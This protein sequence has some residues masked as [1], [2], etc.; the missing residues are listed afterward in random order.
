MPYATI[1]VMCIKCGLEL[2]PDTNGVV[3]LELYQR[4]TQVYKIW[5]ADLVK[6]PGCGIKMIKGFAMNPC[7]IH[8]QGDFDEIL[9]NIEERR[10]NGKVK[11]Y[12]L[13]ELSYAD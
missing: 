5:D 8:H 13:K 10:K 1:P 4:N 12:E 2:V 11:V 9:A 3:V 7:A 6:C